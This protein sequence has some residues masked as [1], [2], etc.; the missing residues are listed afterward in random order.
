MVLGGI[1][2]LTV[3]VILLPFS[4]L[5][6][7]LGIGIFGFT[8]FLTGIVY[9]RNGYR[10][11]RSPRT[12]SSLLTS[13]ATCLLGAFFVISAPLLTGGAIHQAVEISVDD[14]IHGDSQRA[15]AAAH[16][17]GPLKYF[18]GTESN[19]IVT[20]YIQAPDPARKQL[21]KNC[22]QEI[23]GE[24]IEKRIRILQD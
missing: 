22:Y 19:Q 8:P 10:A 17:I 21:L 14:I 5:G 15:S 12:N 18:V 4:L 13:A 24:D 6:L 1:F 3:G 20:A 9:S 7:M 16:R 23:T 11:L 2:C